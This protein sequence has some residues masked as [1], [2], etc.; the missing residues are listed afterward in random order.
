[1]AAA[2][3][4]TGL[5]TWTPSPMRSLGL[6][7]RL[8]LPGPRLEA[9]TALVNPSLS[10]HGN[11]LGRGALGG[12]G[13]GGCLVAGRG[14]GAAAAAVALA[15]APALSAMQR[16]SSERE[17]AARGEAEAVAAA[18]AA[19]KAEAEAKAEAK[20]EAEAKAEAAAGQVRMDAGAAGEPER[21][22]REEQPEAPAPAQPRAP[23]EGD[24]RVPARPLS[25]L[26]PANPKSAPA[27]GLC[28]HGKPKSKGR[29][30]K[31]SSGRRS[32]EYGSQRPVTVD[33]SKARTSLDALKISIRQLKWKEFPFGRRLPCDIYWH[34]VSFHDNDIFCGQVNKFP[35]MTEM[36]RKITLSRA[37]RIM[38]NL[39]PEEYNFYPRSWILP[40]E[41]QLFVAQVRMVKDGDPSWKPT[42]I[43]KPDGGCQGDGIYLIKDPSD[44]RLT[45]TLQSRPAVVQEYIC[46]PLLIDKLKF[47]IRLYVLLKSLEPLEIY[48]AK[49]G[50]SRFC[51]EPYQ[52][53]SPKN[54]HHVFMHLTNYSLN[55]HSRNFVHS[56][57]A[58]TGSKRTFSSILCRLSSKGVDIKKVWSDIISVVIKTVIALTPELKVFYQSDIPTGRPGPTCFQILGFD[59]L[60]MKNLKPI[61]LEV[62]ANPSMRIEH[63]H[64]LSPGV[65][66][67][68]PSLVDEEVKVA[69]IRDTLRLMDPL[70]KKRESQSQQLEKPLAGKEEPL[71]K[72]LTS[73]P[74]GTANPEAHLP[75]ICL[76]QV[77][78]K[79]AKQFNYLRLVDRMANLFIRFLGIKGS[80][81][82]G[83]TGFRT[84]I[85]NCRLS[86]S[87]LSMAAVD[88]L[89]IDITRRWNSMALDQRDSGMCLQ[90]FVE[91]FFFLAQRK[92]KT[93]PLH[94]QVA[95]LIDL[96]EYHLS[97][98][99]EKRLVCGRSGPSGVRSPHSSTPQEPSA[100]AQPAGGD[101]LPRMGYA[102]KLACPRRTLS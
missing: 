60:L 65:F 58:S 15:L 20:V 66:E 57:S 43:V 70:K 51:T 24:A 62:N 48:I 81:K 4:V 30:C 80:M 41:F 86:S 35:G 59:I 85:R 94:E 50:L 45:G 78:P 34:G 96:C 47:D 89:Y 29:S 97:L 8:S 64:E 69:V 76:K 102:S 55:I 68:V 36:V 6:G 39:F 74:D 19:A 23:E 75:S 14:G 18:K 25:T 52:E 12:G 40:D 7:R 13:G 5:V 44:I 10:D 88:I 93:L 16:G 2:A 67:N 61:L 83:P 9:A 49:D 84:F 22:A 82:L 87:S 28:P 77:F 26:P 38:Q 90:A 3:S 31:R 101:V 79:Y 11:G 17:L 32:D 98:L 54:L 21:K 37:V 63:E 53:P 56:D 33:S 92:F 73:A 71:D 46:K 1:M 72:E 27:R 99:D 42:F 100:S 91:A 95:S